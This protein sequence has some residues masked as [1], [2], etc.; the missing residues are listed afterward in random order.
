M[1]KF[2]ELYDYFKF[3]IWLWSQP[4]LPDYENDR[5]DP[6]DEY[7]GSQLNDTGITPTGYKVLVEIPVPHDLQ[8]AEDNGLVIPETAKDRYTN[9]A[10]AA[11]VIQLG[12]ECYT[13]D[14]TTGKFTSGPWCKP[15]D[16]IVMSPYSGT[17]IKSIIM[18]KADYRFIND[19]SIEGIVPGPEFIERGG[20]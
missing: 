11:K 7:F 19:D 20:F 1:S 10:V 6:N 16:W 15:G 2:K 18:G 12:K 13:P 17:R 4:N 9:A 3:K 14:H 8:H 5:D